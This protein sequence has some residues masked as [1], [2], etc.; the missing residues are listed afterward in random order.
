MFRR[1][2][3]I[4]VATLVLFATISYG[5][6]RSKWGF[7]LNAG[8]QRLYGDQKGGFSA[9]F[10]GFASYRTLNFMDL[11][12]SLGYSQIKFFQP[13]FT[14]FANLV[15]ADIKGNFEILSTGRLRPYLTFGLGALVFKHPSNGLGWFYDGLVL[16]GLGLK[17]RLN[18]KFDVLLS[19]DYRQLLTG[20]DLDNPSLGG[21]QG[22]FNDA[23]LNVRAGFSYHLPGKGK[24]TPEVIALE[25]APLT[26]IENEPVTESKGTP[27]QPTQ[28]MEQ[29]VKLK[30][31]IDEL[32][33][34]IDSKESE[35]SRL[36]KNVEEKKQQV[37]TM[38]K[39]VAR[40]TPV[41]YAPRRSFSGFADK[42][43]EALTFYYNKNYNQAINEFE[44][45]LQQYP[46]HSLASNCQYWIGECYYELGRFNDAIIALN[47]VLSYN[48]SP[49]KDDALYLLGMTYLKLGATDRARNAF[50][51][52]V[53]EYPG[54]ELVYDAKEHLNSL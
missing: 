7:G 40:Q 9:G 27:E 4:G 51:R 5:Q 13:G 23:F 54:S 16:G 26:E 47:K 15:N 24:T 8:T 14:R 1:F 50:Q 19:G 30:S 29:Y 21:K 2:S 22:D 37:S 48:R 18:R 52:L 42:Y 3:Y 44:N 6:D 34:Q 32:S 46:N 36:Q 38:S 31:K 49:K 25:K 41:S 20:D 11:V 33:E 45:L 35:I 10:E 28:N 12:L 17:Y 53:D 39:T 43:E